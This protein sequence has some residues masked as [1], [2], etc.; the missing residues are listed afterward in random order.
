VS[1]AVRPGHYRAGKIETIDAIESA[2]EAYGPGAFNGFLA[3]NVL[4]Y[5]SRAPLKGGAEDL[6]KGRWYLDKLLER[7]SPGPRDPAHAEE[8]KRLFTAEQIAKLAQF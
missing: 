7:L 3:G 1:D 5:V 6:A 8:A 2:L 4:K